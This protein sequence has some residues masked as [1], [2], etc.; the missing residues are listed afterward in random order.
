MPLII[1]SRNA[2]K[3]TYEILKKN[4]NFLSNYIVNEFTKSFIGIEGL[5]S[6]YYF[7]LFEKLSKK[8][9]EDS[10]CLFLDRDGV[11]IDWKDYTMKIKDL[12]LTI[13]C[14]KIIKKC[15]KKGNDK[16]KDN[17]HHLFMFI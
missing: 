10:P 15:N 9:F 16:A 2:E 7:F 6:L 13:G 4:F 12:K 17:I 8:N 1:H 11:L 5:A 3:E 14:D